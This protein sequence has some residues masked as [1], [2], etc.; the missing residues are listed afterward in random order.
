MELLPLNV[1]IGPNASGKSNFIEV[2]GLLHA[3]PK[4]LTVPIRKGGG[5]LEWLWKGTA[6]VPT[7]SIELK[8][9]QDGKA[10]PLCYDVS[11]TKGNQWFEVVREI[12]KIGDG[13]EKP[14]AFFTGGYFSS[15]STP[16][17]RSASIPNQSMLSQRK[18]PERYPEITYLGEQFQAIRTYGEWH[19]GRNTPPR[20]P[21]PADARS[22]FLDEDA[23]NLGLVLNNMRLKPK[24]WKH[25]I[26]EFRRFYPDAEDIQVQIIGNTVQLFLT[27]TGMEKPIPA[28]RLSDGTLRYLCLLS[29]LCHPNPP[30]LI[31]LEEPELGLHP[32]CIRLIARLLVEAS[33]RTQLIVTTHSDILISE[34]SDTP[35]AVLVCERDAAGTH[36]RRLEREKLKEWLEKYSLGEIWSMGE[37]GGN[38]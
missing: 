37:I 34:L 11:F 20:L 19:L 4:D 27:E 24:A 36:M 32:D 22:D 18:D 35:E 12:I 38:P 17:M 23:S 31:C 6:E 7:A 16:Q 29:I 2:I 13:G 33:E 15:N 10:K 30:P 9:S 1:L 26:E 14:I 5:I 21:Q 25:L 3:A 28:T 8:L